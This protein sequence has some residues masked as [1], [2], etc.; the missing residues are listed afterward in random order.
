MEVKLK[1]IRARTA[2]RKPLLRCP[3]V[4]RWDGDLVGCGSTRLTE[5]DDEGLYDCID[6]GLFF[7]LDA[8][9]ESRLA[10]PTKL[11]KE[12]R[13]CK[14]M[15]LIWHEKEQRLECKDCGNKFSKNE[16]IKI[17]KRK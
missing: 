9:L 8:A 5:P 11:S 7:K 14:S 4:A 6:C 15:S 2:K 10:C 3:T 1:T 12:K 13:I 16:A 17:A